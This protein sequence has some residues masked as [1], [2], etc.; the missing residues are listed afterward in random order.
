[1]ADHEMRTFIRVVAAKFLYDI[2]YVAG[3]AV[4][5]LRLGPHPDVDTRPGP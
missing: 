4:T 5:V 2:A 1:M 3:L